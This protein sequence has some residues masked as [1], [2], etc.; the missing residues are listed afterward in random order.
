MTQP[1][2]EYYNQ[3]RRRAATIL[4]HMLVRQ[5]QPIGWIALDELVR[6]DQLTFTRLRGTQ[7]IWEEHPHSA[8]GEQLLGVLRGLD[9]NAGCWQ[10]WLIMYDASREE[11]HLNLG[12][13]Y[14]DLNQRIGRILP[15]LHLASAD[16]GLMERMARH[17]QQR[18]ISG[19]LGN[20]STDQR[21][22]PQLEHVLALNADFD[23]ACW[24]HL[25]PAPRAHI[26]QLQDP[27]LAAQ[28]DLSPYAERT[29]AIG[30]GSGRRSSGMLQR[31]LAALEQQ[32]DRLTEGLSTGLW[33]SSIV[34]SA[35]D[36]RVDLLASTLIG[37]YAAPQSLQPL[38][39]QPIGAGRAP[40][41][42]RQV[43]GTE[44][45]G[46]ELAGL[47]TIPRVEYNGFHIAPFASFDQDVAPAQRNAIRLGNLVRG[48]RD[49]SVPYQI[50]RDTLIRHGLVAGLTGS[51][52]SNTCKL[53]VQQIA[54]SNLPVLIVEPAK[55]EYRGL[56]FRTYT[57]GD[58]RVAPLRLNPFELPM[59]D[60]AGQ[61]VQF[62][63]VQ[64]H[65]DYLK[66]V[67]NASFVLFAPMPYVLE[68]CL[69][70]IYI[71]RGWELASGTNR[72][73]M[74][75]DHIFPTL[76]DLYEKIDEVVAT[77]GYDQRLEMDIRAGLLARIDSLR[78]GG[79]G[80]LLDTARSTPT[81]GGLLSAPTVL[82]LEA[83]GNDEDKSFVMGLVLALVYEYRIL[84]AAAERERGGTAGQ[85][86]R[87]L[88]LIEEAHRL[89]AQ[90][91]GGG[92]SGDHAD[93]GGQMLAVFANMLAE[94]RAYG[95]G[96]LIVDQIP[97]RLDPS[98]VKNTE[99]KIIHKLVAPDDRELLAKTS[100][101]SDTQARY[102]STLPIGYA[103]VHAGADDRP[104]LVHIGTFQGTPT[105]VPVASALPSPL[106][107]CPEY[108]PAWRRDG[109]CPLP[110]R[111]IGRRIAARIEPQH[112]PGI[113]A[114][115]AEGQP[116]VLHESMLR[117]I[118]ESARHDA[119]DETPTV[120][121][122]A[123]LH[124]ID[125][126][127][128]HFEHTYPRWPIER[129]A[130]LVSLC[131]TV[132]QPH[133]ARLTALQLV[134]ARALIAAGPHTLCGELC[135]QRCRYRLLVE[136]LTGPYRHMTGHGTV[137]TG[138]AAAVAGIAARQ[139]IKLWGSPAPQ[140][141][142]RSFRTCLLIHLA[143]QFDPSDPYQTVLDTRDILERPAK[144]S[145]EQQ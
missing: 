79:R 7:A 53:I 34:V 55:A 58:E 12:A 70:E 99:L 76:T 78:T 47:V 39:V 93:V 69:H 40:S 45:L 73:A 1:P 50:E 37:A 14:P 123:A 81:V 20:R 119:P 127:L 10:C 13:P 80:L 22:T 86:L 28:E 143:Q 64:A 90:R 135:E 52:K 31:T 3:A 15:Y 95:Q 87:H 48:L 136:Q 140:L 120:R 51:G 84:E 114:A 112:I 101:L 67:F 41:D 8:I 117:W 38:I 138:T 108:C 44:H 4:E 145:E 122:C 63:S 61:G 88:V 128:R 57:L 132:P 116:Y 102:V 97:G 54:T 36:D 107:S 9:G 46:R 113:I 100:N 30:S 137:R 42:P 142:H 89:L 56:R 130:E 139:E 5:Q 24:V 94:M 35:P 66:A 91:Q 26:L 32:L 74:H 29:F 75:L 19:I 60:A 106:P 126:G 49:T 131:I 82:E 16:T 133:D 111:E 105:I 72:R 124:V 83:I 110:L 65:I 103:V 43:I 118:D 25:A 92:G 59:I 2:D 77:L 144:L 96:F 71:D 125:R 27:L 104:H 141:A 62:A 18:I 121:V 21:Y 11:I 68:R 17:S 23:W 115:A 33:M 98:V 134:L 109:R 129:T 6:R 85:G